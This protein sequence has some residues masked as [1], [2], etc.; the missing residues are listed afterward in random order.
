M[1]ANSKFAKVKPAA[2]LVLF[3]LFIIAAPTW[4]NAQSNTQGDAL[5]N[6]E[7]ALKRADRLIRKSADLYRKD[8]VDKAILLAEEA[9]AIR[10]AELPADHVDIAASLSTLGVL[11]QAQGALD[12]SETV[13]V[14][15]LAIL[16][17]TLPPGHQKIGIALNNLAGLYSQKS[18]LKKSEVFFRRALTIMEQTLPHNDQRRAVSLN[19]LASLYQM[20]GRLKEAAPLFARALAIFENNLPAG[21]QSITLSVNNLAALYQAL[22]HYE[23]AVP[24]FKRSLA[25]IQ[26]AHPQGH[27]RAVIV[28]NNLAIAYKSLKRGAEAQ[29]AYSQALSLAQKTLPAGHPITATLFS[30]L[31]QLHKDQ[32]RPDQAEIALQKALTLRQRALPANHLDI[33]DNLSE[34][35]ILKLLRR[36]WRGAHELYTRSSKILIERVKRGIGANASDRAITAAATEAST[37]EGDFMGLIKAAWRRS[38]AQPELHDQLARDTFLQAQWAKRGAAAVA[39]EQMAVRIATNDPARSKLL[40]ERQNLLS[41]WQTL[42]R[43]LVAATAK[44]ARNRD[45]PAEQKQRRRRQDI[46]GRVQQIDQQIARDYPNV[47]TLTQIKP[48][49]VAGVQ[50]QLG[51][52]EAVV[53]MLDSWAI[54]GTP[55]ET[56]IWVITRQDVRWRRTAIGTDELEKSVDILRCGLDRTGNWQWDRKKERWIAVTPLCAKLWPAGL[57]ATAPLPFNAGLAHQ[58]YVK[59]FGKVEQLIKGKN[60]LFVSTG[61]LN[62]LPLQVLV[63]A[64]PAPPTPE[65]QRNYGAISWFGQAHAITVLPTVASLTALRKQAGTSRAKR[66]YIGFGNPLLTGFDGKDRR[67]FA[68]QNCPKPGLVGRLRLSALSLSKSITALFR[69]GGVDIESL[70][71][72]APLPETA[73]EICAVARTL[74][75][76]LANAVYLGARNSES[77]LKS[78]SDRGALAQAR[79]L[80]FATHGLIAGETSLFTQARAEPSLVLTPPAK[81]VARDDGLLSASEVSLLNL[82]ADWVILSACNTASGS[83][84]KSDAFSGLAS[85]F[86]FA[87]ARSLLVSHW[88]VDSDATVALITGAFAFQKTQ[89]TLGRAEALRR[90]MDKLIRSKERFSHPAFWA[91]FVLVGEGYR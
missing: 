67:A 62:T 85:A 19:N 13:L 42:D 24:L 79:V 52:D 65:G 39:L 23:K 28:H 47:A 81:A 53:Y 76:D 31:A 35:A 44:E 16:E 87:G 32:G 18:Q 1:R 72:Q 30:N 71:R 68:K 63:T 91:P 7:T 25:L 3:G 34:L 45:R 57:A 70:R 2:F 11:Y 38:A 48:L 56:F 49:S 27:R 90:S 73:D 82:N 83:N 51:P 9:L 4:T 50:Q 88:Y 60:L 61:A 33:A 75:A 78:L 36:D 29:T 20:Q 14:R 8:N 59:L 15:A 84:S 21:H 12:K 64:K 89:P 22:K 10:R 40:R 66:P 55:G 58:L 5:S 54:G 74:E 17:K 41:E 86:F 26:K 6:S 37:A 77:V 46:D 43:A 69:G 80:H